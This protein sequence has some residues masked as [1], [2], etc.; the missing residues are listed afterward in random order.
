MESYRRVA[1]VLALILGAMAAA[2][3]REWLPAAPDPAIA[4][5]SIVVAGAAQ[6]AAAHP[7]QPG[8]TDVVTAQ[9]GPQRLGWNDRERIL[10]AANVGSSAFGK[11]FEVQVDGTVFG[12][13]LIVSGLD[14]P[15]VGRRNVLVVATENDSVYALDADTGATLWRHT[16]GGGFGVSAATATSLYPNCPQINPVVGV[17]S[18]P[19]IDRSTGTVYVVAKTMTVHGKKTTFQNSLHALALATGG[20]RLPPVQI[21]DRVDLSARG[22]FAPGRQVLH[23]L[24]RVLLGGTYRFDPRAQMNRP[25][26]LLSQGKIYIAFSSHCDD[27]TAHGWVFAYDASTLARVSSF[28]T[29]GDWND[30]NGGGVWQSG[31]GLTADP[32]G[33]VYFTTGNGDFDA[34]DGGRDYGDALLK[35]SPDLGRVVDYFAP[36]NQ[37]ELEA[38]D[39]DY[40]GGGM[41][42]LPD[43]PGR[44]PHLAVVATK[45]RAL[46]LF[47]RE[48]LG[49][50]T[51][52]GPDRVLQELGDREDHVRWCIGTCGAA[53]YYRGPGGEYV[54]NVWAL[55]AMRAYRLVRGERP[56][57]IEVARSPN[58]FPG[59]GG[60]SPSVSSDGVR[61]GSAIVWATTR[62]SHVRTEP[63][64]LYAYD[65][66]DIS[67]VLYHGRVSMWRN[68][69]G[70]PFLTP[71][72]ANGKVY[73][74]GDRSVSAF[75]LLPAGSAV[76]QR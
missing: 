66:S 1:I 61:P 2:R 20:D 50:Y 37:A 11:L 53:A 26:L 34:A 29:I 21:T 31:S 9:Y 68:G 44:Y 49:G 19:V 62:P 38:Y 74:G 51:P 18:T 40:G 16:F 69:F 25:A 46:F 33:N 73:V 6:P 24:K 14:V 10:S 30:V 48:R 35:L 67:R 52:N 13:P 28:V 63:I 60:T 55:D 4:R 43:G 57:L 36:S 47:D 23:S 70:N 75:G 17:S 27:P 5:A 42:A 59:E 76:A 72:V 7:W 12:Q 56:R 64:E 39:A 71:T 8:T 22:A 32:D 41:L 3:M 45:L 15:G 58:V 65:G 54:V